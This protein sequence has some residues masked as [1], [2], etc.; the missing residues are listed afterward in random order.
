MLCCLSK[1]AYKI[2]NKVLI[3]KCRFRQHTQIVVEIHLM[4]NHFLNFVCPKSLGR[5]TGD[6]FDSVNP[7][8]CPLGH[9]RC[10][11]DIRPE[12]VRQALGL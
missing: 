10:L 6:F 8:V 4:V 3:H 1:V 9:T 12:R 11:N 5:P 2:K 7:G